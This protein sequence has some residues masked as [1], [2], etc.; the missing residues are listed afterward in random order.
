[1]YGHNP[2]IYRIMSFFPSPYVFFHFLKDLFSLA[3]LALFSAWNF[4]V[5]T[6][7]PFSTISRCVVFSLS[8]S[9]IYT[10][11]HSF[12]T[13]GLFFQLLFA[14]RYLILILTIPTAKPFI[15]YNAK[16]WSIYQQLTKCTKT[17]FFHLFISKF[18]SGSMDKPDSCNEYAET[19]NGKRDHHVENPT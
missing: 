2:G 6:P 12:L 5:I 4:S 19:K 16:I 18:Y 15:F 13:S 14:L 17:L 11:T 9:Q 10:N 8:F 3:F 7:L 1:M